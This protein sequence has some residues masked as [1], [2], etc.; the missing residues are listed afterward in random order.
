MIF[1]GIASAEGTRI[2]GGDPTTIDKYPSIVQVDGLGFFSGVWGQICAANILNVLYVLSA[3][4]CFLGALYT[5][6]RR[7][8]RAGSTFRNASGII[9]EVDREFNHPTYGLL[10][11]DGDITVVRLRTPFVYSNVIQPGAIVMPNYE[12]PDNQPV[13]HAGWGATSQGGEASDVLLDVTIYTVNRQLCADRYSTLGDI[14]TENMIC[15]G[16]LDVG[17][18]DACQGDSGGPLYFHNVLVGVV[19]WGEGCANNTFPGVSA[20]VSPYTQWIVDTAV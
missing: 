14:I 19:S 15:A 4:H 3:A 10:D 16:I 1:V 13:V 9:L 18:K 8:I 20:A 5:P 11:H 12:V 6:Q 7:R 2:V 17:G